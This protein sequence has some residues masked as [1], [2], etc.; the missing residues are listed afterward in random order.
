MTCEP[1]VDDSLRTYKLQVSVTEG[2]NR[3]TGCN[4]QPC[5]EVVRYSPHGSL[6]VQ[7]SPEG[8]DATKQRDANDQKHVQPIHM[9]VPIFPCDWAFCDVFL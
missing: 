2:P 9:F 4:T 5:H 7:R 8:L 6:P 1:I 3:L